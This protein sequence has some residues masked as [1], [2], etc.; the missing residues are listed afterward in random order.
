[1]VANIIISLF[2]FIITNKL[3]YN[4]YYLYITK[5]FIS[6][7]RNYIV[8]RNVSFLIIIPVLREQNIIESTLNYF[9]KLDLSNIDLHVCIAGTS[10]E[11]NENNK[12][13][14]ST[15]KIVNKWIIKEKVNFRK[16]IHF[17]Y[18]EISETN[19]DRATQLNYAVKQCR[20]YFEPE[21]VGVYDADSL[22]DLKTLEEVAA[23]YCRKPNTVFQQPVH[24]ISAA[25]RMAKKNK[26]PILV[27]NALY[28]TTWT[29]IRELPR[30]KKHS[31]FCEKNN[32][33]LY[34]KNDYLIG[35]GE[36]IPYKLYNSFIFPEKEVTDGIQLG[37][38]LSMSGYSIKP[39]HKFCVDDVPQEISQLIKQHK[40]WFAG[41][42][43]LYNSYKWCK[44]N[45]NRASLFQ[46]LDGFWSQISW[47]YASLFAIVVLILSIAKAFSNSW[48]FLPIVLTEIIIYSYVIP[49]IAN[50]IMPK[51]IRIRI[52]DW[53]CLPIAIALKGIGPNVYL[54]QKFYSLILK[55]EITYS[56]VER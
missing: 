33:R 19:G 20:Q 38:R 3:F 51:K 40:R 48:W 22:P 2:I 56:K 1:M 42:N 25:N 37:Y 29:A 11:K 10:R 7:E 34:Y 35:H 54:I 24:F 28:Q 46:M 15:G 27:A 13:Y 4:F 31:E 50:F 55:N 41:C 6:E 36:F 12:C 26:N 45:F 47:A 16:N 18:V 49:L 21:L 32:N 17:S 5:K 30:W 39:I 44:K 14:I 52:I 53:L 23:E 43:R 9:N 8:N